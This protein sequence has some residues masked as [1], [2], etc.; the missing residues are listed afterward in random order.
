MVQAFLPMRIHVFPVEEPLRSNASCASSRVDSSLTT[1]PGAN[2]PSTRAIAGCE[3]D[4][5]VV[6][7]GSS[8]DHLAPNHSLCCELE[9]A[10]IETKKQERSAHLETADRDVSGRGRTDGIDDEIEARNQRVDGCRV[11]PK[12]NGERDP[13]RIDVVAVHG[14]AAPDERN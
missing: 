14:D 11:H 3:V 10:I 7:Q 5:V 2:P 1:R 9:W 6:G 12:P 8:Q 4:G 13:V